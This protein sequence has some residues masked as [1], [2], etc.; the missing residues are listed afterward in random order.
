MIL[1]PRGSALHMEEASAG[2]QEWPGMD[3]D[4]TF[5]VK[6]DQVVEWGDV[7]SFGHVN[8]CKYFRYYENVRLKYFEAMGLDC[9]PP[10]SQPAAPRGDNDW[11]GCGPI[12]AKIS[13]DF[14]RPLF[15]PDRIRIE[16]GVTRIG[17]SSF[18]VGYRIFSEAQ[19]VVVAEAESVMV[20]YSYADKAS[21]ALPEALLAKVRKLE[22]QP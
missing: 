21:R 15:Y 1:K 20:F 8:N 4:T 11:S 7:D 17:R 9:S 14:K 5:P 6:M 12:L 18:H 19:Q 2:R 13:T 3:I 10:S 22:G 16:C